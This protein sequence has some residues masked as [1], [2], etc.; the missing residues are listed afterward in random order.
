MGRHRREESTD[1]DVAVLHRF[2]EWK[3]RTFAVE[4]DEVGLRRNCLVPQL[5]ELADREYFRFI[6]Q[7][8]AVWNL[9]GIVETRAGRSQRHDVDAVPHLMRAQ[10]LERFLLRDAVAAAESR[11]A[12]NF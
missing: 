11:H 8:L 5:I 12:I 6:I 4:Y 7:S 1:C 2:D 10:L 3:D 9:I